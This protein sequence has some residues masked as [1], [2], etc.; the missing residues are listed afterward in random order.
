MQYQIKGD[1]LPVAICQLSPGESLISEVG[2]MGWMSDN[3]IMDTNM[4]GGLFGGIGRAFSGESV[5]LNT[6]TCQGNNNG[7]I[8]FPSSVPGKI[9]VRHL[10]P[11]ETIICQ[12][13]S[14]LAGEPSLDL[15]VH[16]R[17]RLGAGFFGGEGFILQKITGPG[18]VFLELDGHIEEYNLAPG[19]RIVVDTGNVA[20]FDASVYFDVQMVKG[21]KNV[22]FGGEGLFLTTLTGPGRVYLQSMPVQNLA[23]RIISFLP[24]SSK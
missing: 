8:A 23:S 21:L 16:F 11:G 19:Q 4:K 13:G 12:K 18:V 7:I 6:F 9:M 14:F 15:K 20:F 5:F 17:K 2:A 1:S 22:L 10:A 3:I 24:N